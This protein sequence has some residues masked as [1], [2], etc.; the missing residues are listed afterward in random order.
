M[1]HRRRSS[2]PV[3]SVD[4]EKEKT[5]SKPQS[6]SSDV[7]SADLKSNLDYIRKTLGGSTDIMIREISLDEKDG[8]KVAVLYTDG[9]AD[10]NTITE[11]IMKTLARMVNSSKVAGREQ[12]PSFDGSQIL[13]EISL[14]NK[15]IQNF[16]K[17]K[18]L[19]HSLLSGDTIFL[20]DGFEDGIALGTRGWKD[21]GV[22]ETSVENVVRGPREAFTESL[23]TNTA[24]IRRKIKDPNLWL[25]TRQIGRLTQTD[26]GLMYINGIA[27]EKIVQ[28]A[29][30]RL[31]RIDIGSILESGYIEEA[32]QDETMTPF[33]TI[34]N[35]E[36]PDVIAAE[37]L[38]GKIAILVDGTPFVLV[39]PALF[40][41]FLH[42]AEDYYQRSDISSFLRMLRYLSIFISLLGPSLYI[43]VST[44]HQEML[45]TQLLFGLAA[46]R[47]QIPFPAFVEAVLMEVTF[48]ILREAGLR[49][50]KNIGSAISIV[51]TLVIGQAAVE[52]GIISAAMVIVVAITAIS[53]FVLPAFN[54]SIAFRML[55][56]PLMALAGSFGLY[57]IFIG[58]TTLILH[59]CS[60]RSFGVPYMAPFAPLIPDDQ[61]DAVLRLP[62][63]MLMTRPRLINK[64]N[65][66]RRKSTPPQK[67]RK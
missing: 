34:F 28:E 66:T 40:V 27:N 37:L 7:L 12:I 6:N 17:Y 58:A 14:Q 49:L 30:D 45:P 50:P 10:Q 64:D 32:I 41:S 9:L 31:D 19:F 42:A 43:A 33:P 15:E 29:R 3:R 25:E 2:H 60:L 24:M 47:E 36:R 20:V 11:S 8:L 46:Q 65:V 61:K 13:A 55:R 51:G 16:S 44:F 4:K 35:T 22:T 38:E 54:M 21:R 53:S 59:L 39:M 63:W 62:Q 23:R 18:T 48:E 26:V 67:S 56:F 57:G 1:R 5:S 52:A